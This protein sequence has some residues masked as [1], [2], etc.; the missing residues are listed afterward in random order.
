MA[1]LIVS[2]GIVTGGWIRFV[3]FPN[4]PSDFIMVQLEMPEG[5]ASDETGRAIQRLVDALEQVRTET[6]DAGQIDPVAHKLVAVGYSTFT[7][8]PN[9]ESTVTGSN[10]G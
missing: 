6:I 7:G 4:V 10:F 9:P 5:T 8:G 1:I 3:Q 2:I